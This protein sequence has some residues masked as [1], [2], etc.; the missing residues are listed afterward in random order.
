M[1]HKGVNK[2]I[3]EHTFNPLPKELLIK[4]GFC[5]GMQCRNCPYI[6]KHTYGSGK[7]KPKKTKGRKKRR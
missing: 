1:R 4:R 6:P 7:I 3:E 5:C 2:N